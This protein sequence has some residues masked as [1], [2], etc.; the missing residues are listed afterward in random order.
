MSNIRVLS[1]ENPET[2]KIWD[3][4]LIGS[5]LPMPMFSF[6][7]YKSWVE[8]H[9]KDW[10]P[11]I[12]LI[13][14]KTIAPFVKSSSLI[15]FAHYYSDF[16]DLV[17]STEESWPIILDFLKQN[18]IK[19]INLENIV[20]DSVTVSFFKKYLE[21]NTGIITPAKTAPFLT[22]PATFEE[23]ISTVKSKRRKYRKFQN[24]FPD[25]QVV[26]SIEP[27][28]DIDILL[29]LLKMDPAKN[30]SSE[31][32]FF[33]KAIAANCK[34][35][36]WMQKLEFNGDVAG[37][38]FMFT[39]NEKVML[40][41][42]GCNKDLYPNIGTYLIMEAIKLSIEQKYKEFSFLRG[43]EAYKYEL[44]AQDLL[45]YTVTIDL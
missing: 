23:Y 24:D 27:E 31:K 12:L 13:N 35:Y 25:A 5:N 37:V 26:K 7:W 38:L 1:I 8:A 32:D 44:G 21:T 36:I 45:L 4:I 28:K 19:Q 17:G 43:R 40:Y 10:E 15:Q 14:D 3:Q 11:Y 34:S 22:L 16:N 41:I 6:E 39:H 30:V 29:S 42:N 9:N 33:S 20:Q 2:K 18:G